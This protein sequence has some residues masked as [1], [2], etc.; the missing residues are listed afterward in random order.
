MKM[1]EHV[2]VYTFLYRNNFDKAGS[3]ETSEKSKLL[4]RG[5]SQKSPHKHS[6]PPQTMHFEAAARD[7]STTKTTELFTFP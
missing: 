7:K 5:I 3:E 4:M 1:N 2:R 6:P